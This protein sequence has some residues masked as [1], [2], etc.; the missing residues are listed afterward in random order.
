MFSRGEVSTC[1]VIA[2]NNILSLNFIR[3]LRVIITLL[4]T[5]GVITTQSNWMKFRLQYSKGCQIL[6]SPK[7]VVSRCTEMEL[8]KV[9]V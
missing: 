7:G 6:N 8:D 9:A 4:V 2:I 5:E 3:L 1:V